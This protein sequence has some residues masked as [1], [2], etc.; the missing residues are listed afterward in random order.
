MSNH[1]AAT[2]ATVTTLEAPL[3][4]IDPCTGFSAS[5]AEPGICAGCG[6]LDDEHAAPALAA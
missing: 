1:Q 5:A 3:V 6:W 2:P 4:L